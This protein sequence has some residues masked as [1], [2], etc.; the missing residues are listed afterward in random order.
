MIVAIC[1]ILS[2]VAG[3]IATYCYWT[4][5]AYDDE[6]EFISSASKQELAEVYLSAEELA[7]LNAMP[8]V[9]KE[10]ALESLEVEM[11]SKEEYLQMM[12]N[13]PELRSAFMSDC[14]QSVFF[15]LLGSFTL[16][17]QKSKNEKKAVSDAQDLQSARVDSNA[18]NVL[19]E[20]A[21]PDAVETAEET[22]NN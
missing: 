22:T 6:V 15:A 8:N 20:S 16:I 7:E 3:D 14:C 10:Y 21:E 2:V 17:L 12:R 4:Y 11:P 18:D 19:A 13:D 9:L 5:T 1:V